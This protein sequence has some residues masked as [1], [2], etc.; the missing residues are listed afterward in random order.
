MGSRRPSRVSV[1]LDSSV[2][3]TSVNSPSG[4]SAKLFTAEKFHLC[5]S[6]TVLAEVE[7]NVRQKLL[8]EHLQRFFFLVNQMTLLDQLPDQQLVARAQKVI[9]E[10]DAIIL[11]EA[12]QSKVDVV[13]TL[14]RKHFLT[15]NV[16]LW[17]KP[18]RI[19]TPK[20][21]LQGSWPLWLWNRR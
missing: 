21:L 11:A 4:G 19:V 6:L 12:K 3:F 13:A 18:Q 8:S 7:R 5:T 1:F 14:D 2:L 20:M 10:K 17:M 15:P 9:V 16:A